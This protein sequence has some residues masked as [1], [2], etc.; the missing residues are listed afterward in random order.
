VRK[1]SDGEQADD[2]T[3]V[4]ARCRADFGHG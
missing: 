4:I 2:I 3:L 1:F